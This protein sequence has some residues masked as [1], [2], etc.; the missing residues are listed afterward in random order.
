MKIFEKE[1]TGEGGCKESTVV[2]AK[3]E[4]GKCILHGSDMGPSVERLKGSSEYEY[5]LTIKADELPALWPHLMQHV[6]NATAPLTVWKVR[7]LCQN[8]GIN[9]DFW[10][11]P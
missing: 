6:T 1:W 10:T 8:A 7:E 5:G 9:P 2:W 3:V 4:D 11:H